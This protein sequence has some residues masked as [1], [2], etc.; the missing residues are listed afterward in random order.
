MADRRSALDPALAARLVT[1]GDARGVT[2]REVP[3]PAQV[4]AVVRHR[5][6]GQWLAVVQT[7]QALGGGWRREK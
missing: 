3:F 4:G 2:I 5:A 7:Y 6:S 1:L